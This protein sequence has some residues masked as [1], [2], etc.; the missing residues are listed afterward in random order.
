MTT[1]LNVFRSSLMA[2]D[3]YV[4]WH[5]KDLFMTQSPSTAE[6]DLIYEAIHLFLQN[7]SRARSVLA[8]LFGLVGAPNPEDATSELLADMP[9]LIVAPL[10][11]T[12]FHTRTRHMPRYIFVDSELSCELQLDSTSQPAFAVREVLTGIICHE[13]AN[14]A[15]ARVRG[16]EEKLRNPGDFKLS[17]EGQT[18][19]AGDWFEIHLFGGIIELDMDEGH[20]TLET[21]DNKYRISHHI[22]AAEPRDRIIH[23][24][25]VYPVDFG[26]SPSSASKIPSRTKDDYDEDKVPVR[27]RCRGVTFELPSNYRYRYKQTPEQLQELLALVRKLEA[28]DA[29]ALGPVMPK[30]SDM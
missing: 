30:Q 1:P 9:T 24:P 13:L 29:E 14:C 11:H 19:E 27:T 4:H 5:A 23:F 20:A 22:L 18:T 10:M 2:E 6:I 8:S 16:G 12:A 28:A 7:N 3:M 26:S 15:V 21:S 25:T 17:W